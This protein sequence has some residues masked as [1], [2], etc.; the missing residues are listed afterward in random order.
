MNKRQDKGTPM[1][2]ASG[3]AP[4]SS[5]EELRAAAWAEHLRVVRE[6]GTYP[7][8]M[9]VEDLRRRAAELRGKD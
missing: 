8:L 6:D 4:Q 3:T 7:H 5:I 2:V 9:T 1:V